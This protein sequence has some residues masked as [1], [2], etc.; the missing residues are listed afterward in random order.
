MRIT[1]EA[2]H[3]I[4]HDSAEKYARRYRGL[5][6]IYLTGSLLSDSPLLGGTT[7][8]DLVC[9][10]TSTPAYPREVVHLSDEVHLDIAHYSQTVFHQPRHLR[11]DPWVGS[12]LVNNAA[13]LYDTQHWFEFTQASAG[14]QFNQPENV[15]TRARKL[16]E[17]ARQ[18][19]MSLHLQPDPSAPARLLIYLSALENAANSITV[20]HAAPLTERRFILQ[21][22]E[23]A[24]AVGRPGMAAGL[25]DL[26]T[27]DGY[28]AQD[29]TKWFEPWKE[30]L[31]AASQI[32]EVSPRLAPT[33]LLYYE[34][35]AAALN[36]ENTPA[37]LWLVLRTWTR[38]VN[39]LPPDA[40][41][42]TPWV[43]ACHELGLSDKPFDERLALL[44]SY[45]DGVEETLDEWA[46]KYGV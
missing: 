28:S 45:L 9:V 20:I 13:A 1:R 23:Y 37:A 33:R 6:C 15:V 24:Q 2:L 4:A 42:Q 19:W 35:A 12:H 14:A 10:H 7:D 18:S 16:A 5:A 38:V 8:I 34:R 30:S 26:F 25:L 27:P 46:K 41:Q 36:E 17:N 21:F 11:V 31:Q 22:P 39:A 44:D 29:L 32:E 43:D 3:A 40:R